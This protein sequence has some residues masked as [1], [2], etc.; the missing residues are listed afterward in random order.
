MCVYAW[1]TD[2]LFGGEVRTLRECS[3]SMGKTHLVVQWPKLLWPH[4]WIASEE[5]SPNFH[6]LPWKIVTVGQSSCCAIV[7]A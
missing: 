4:L 6:A 3:I 5:S 1:Q 7:G 2:W